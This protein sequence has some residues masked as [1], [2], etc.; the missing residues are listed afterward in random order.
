LR[1]RISFRSLA[2]PGA[3]STLSSSVFETGSIT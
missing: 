3:E 1:E 2:R